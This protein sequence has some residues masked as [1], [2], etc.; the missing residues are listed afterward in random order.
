MIGVLCLPNFQSCGGVCY[1]AETYI[2]CNNQLLDT[3][4]SCSDSNSD[5][6]DATEAGDD[7]SKD[8]DDDED[9]DKDRDEHEEDE[10]VNEDADENED[11]DVNERADSSNDTGESYEEEMEHSSPPKIIRKGDTEDENEHHE[12]DGENSGEDDG[13]KGTPK[14]GDL[15]YDPATCTCENGESFKI[16]R[17]GYVF[18]MLTILFRCNLS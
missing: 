13:V 6:Q 14:C 1:D 2:C 18:Q 8:D 10:A 16:L 12:Y 17:Y 7:D 9:E 4:S 3:G 15:E 5:E 11:M